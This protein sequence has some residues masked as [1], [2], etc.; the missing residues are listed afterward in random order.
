MCYGTTIILYA[1]YLIFG[2]L[3]LS[4]TKDR[5][6]FVPSSSLDEISN[7][8][9][10]DNTKYS[11][12]DYCDETDYCIVGDQNAANQLTSEK[13]WRTFRKMSTDNNEDPKEP[14]T[15]QD[16]DE[17]LDF[18]MMRSVLLANS[19]S[20]PKSGE[21]FEI[22]ND[23]VVVK[24]GDEGWQICYSENDTDENKWKAQDGTTALHNH[25]LGDYIEHLL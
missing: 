21:D 10:C 8:N 25:T 3:F 7:N 18:D 16:D 20:F 5:K 2:I 4:G 11:V 1:N 6:I 14:M 9:G 13:L 19:S 15:N 22:L 12:I 24:D 23:G 17:S